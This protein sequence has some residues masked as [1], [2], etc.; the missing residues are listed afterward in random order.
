MI[1]NRQILSIPP[2]VSTSWSEVKALYVQEELLFILLYEGTVIQIPRLSPQVLEQI[3]QAHALYLEEQSERPAKEA[4]NPLHMFFNSVQT[5]EL[6]FSLALNG[7]EMLGGVL[8]HNV[9]QAHRSD[10]PEEVLQK[11]AMAAR[12]LGPEER[13]QLP[14]AEP[15]CNCIHCQIMRAIGHEKREEQK[16]EKEEGQLQP[17]ADSVE[18]T[19]A[20]QGIWLV[21]QCGE[22]LFQVTHRDEPT[23]VYKVFLGTPLGCTCGDDRCIH[24][25]AVLRS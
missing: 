9:E 18:G 25:L 17:P 5:L 6:P 24:I 22:Q 11:I 20:S 14:C 16:R 15:H 1:I 7:L 19:E 21:E 13:E 8:H 10:L 4:Q 12:L 2:H 23:E 3:F